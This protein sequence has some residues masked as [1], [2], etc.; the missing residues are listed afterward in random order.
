MRTAE[1][2]KMKRIEDLTRESEVVDVSALGD[3]PPTSVLCIKCKRSLDDLSNIRAAVYGDPSGRDGKK[4]CEVFRS[5]LPNLRG[6]RPSKNNEWIRTCMRS[7]LLC[8]MR[9]DV[10][11]L[12]IKGEISR[13]PH[14]VYA[15]FEKPMGTFIDVLCLRLHTSRYCGNGC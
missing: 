12:Q 2:E 15:W 7:I 11:L 13:F 3:S 6:R 4:K 8:K 9:E 14:F 5:L 10:S 1:L